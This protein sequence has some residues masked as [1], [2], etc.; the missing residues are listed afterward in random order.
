MS[1]W[2]K[3]VEEFHTHF[4]CPI[5]YI[6]HIPHKEREKLRYDLIDEEVNRELLPALLNKDLVGIADGCADAIVVII[7]T[8]LE[9]GIPLDAVFNEVMR[10]NMSKLGE[11]GKP[12]YREDGK[13]LK[14][15]KYSP[16]EIQTIINR[17]QEDVL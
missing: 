7:G 15:P 8:C 4:N 13:V 10:A 14:G 3:A 16:P 2:I 12:I 11:D 9:Y 5:K 17:A 6:P 1:V